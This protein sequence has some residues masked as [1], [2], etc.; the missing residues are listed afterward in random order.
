MNVRKT[1][2]VLT[3]ISGI[4]GVIVSGFTLLIGVLFT[5]VDFSTL[6]E[7]EA[8]TDELEI[9][10]IMGGGI[11][12]IAAIALI[13]SIALIII[14]TQLKKNKNTVVYGVIIL[15]LAIIPFFLLTFLWT[16]SGIL[17]VIAGI[18]MLSRK[19]EMPEDPMA[20]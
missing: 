11:A 1:E 4:V 2:S 9:L 6:P 19:V 5:A 10:G 13:I 7:L 14:S 8:T 17:G 20:F 3:L 12:V 15:I 16:I 18:M